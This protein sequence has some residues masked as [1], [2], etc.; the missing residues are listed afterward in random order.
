M[1]NEALLT[2]LGISLGLTLIL[3]VG[4]F[5]FLFYVAK[6]IW[7]RGNNELS[8]APTINIFFNAKWNKRDILLVI[9]VN[10]L[11][12]PIVVLVYWILY[13]NTNWNTILIIIPL[14]VFAVLTE[15]YI[16]K[17]N[18]EC[19]K[20]PFLFSLLVNAFSYSAGLLISQFLL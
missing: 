5:F 11:T 14:E 13:Y 7:N 20:R 2:A 9:L 1:S 15:G 18:S 19:I 6:L 3:E 12:N 16:Y 8:P 10:T 4:F 17:R